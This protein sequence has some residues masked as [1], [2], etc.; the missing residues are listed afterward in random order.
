MHDTTKCGTTII[1]ELTSGSTCVMIPL[2]TLSLCPSLLEISPP[3]SI[4]N[5]F[6]NEW[7]SR[8]LKADWTNFKVTNKLQYS[9][10]EIPTGIKLSWMNRYRV[11]KVMRQPYMAYILLK[12]GNITMPIPN[13]QMQK[14]FDYFKN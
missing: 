5:V 10:I 6:L 9:T 1:L 3:S 2:L 8:I 7:P 13:M 4:S 11:M 12:H 14:Y